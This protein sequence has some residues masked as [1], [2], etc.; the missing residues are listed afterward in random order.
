MSPIKL[1]IFDLDGTLTDSIADLTDAVN[2]MRAD[3]LLSPLA[4]G[5]VRGMVGRGARHLVM[6]ALPGASE[7]E[8]ERGLA[9]FL[10]YN[11][12]HIA[13]K[14]ILYPGVWDTL[15][16]LRNS[17]SK[18][19]VLSNKN[20]GLCRKLLVKLEVAEMFAEICGADAHPF[21]KPSPKPIFSLMRKYGADAGRTVIIGDSINDIS[22]GKQAGI[23]TIGC[24]YGYGG[25]DDLVDADYRV[26]SFAELL[27]L[28]I[29]GDS[30]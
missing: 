18:L 10:E 14:T 17:S 27:A 21:M 5:E 25:P 3:F 22:A 2:A 8:R 12:L 28:P 19:V 24:T 20:T 1:I 6:Q 26:G 30:A 29:L 7:A 4:V 13:D 11:E 15:A 23:R 16:V 9:L